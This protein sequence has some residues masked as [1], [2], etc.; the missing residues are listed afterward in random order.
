MTKTNSELFTL[1]NVGPAVYKDLTLLGIK[2]I[3]ELAKE[4]PDDLYI[5]LQQITV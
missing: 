3:K 2:S 4:D 5:Q 1:K